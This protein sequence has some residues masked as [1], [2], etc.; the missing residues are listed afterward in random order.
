MNG[1]GIAIKAWAWCS[2]GFG[3]DGVVIILR[4]SHPFSP[5]ISSLFRKILGSYF[6]EELHGILT[7]PADELSRLRSEHVLQ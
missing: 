5:S 2:G 1:F 4:F 3:P 7:T 6:T